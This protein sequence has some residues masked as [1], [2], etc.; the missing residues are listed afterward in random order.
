MLSQIG[1]KHPDAVPACARHSP[2]PP[3]ATKPGSPSV[4][5]IGYG[6]LGTSLSLDTVLES[7]VPALLAAA[8]QADPRTR[9]VIVSLLCRLICLFDREDPP[10]PDTALRMCRSFWR[11]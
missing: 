7:A 8:R 9:G 11:L 1:L 10:L 3:R 4:I 2:I 6:R 5:L